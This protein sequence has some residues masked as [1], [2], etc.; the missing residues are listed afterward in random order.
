MDRGETRRRDVILG[1]NQLRHRL[2][3]ELFVFFGMTEG[4][5][6]IDQK[7]FS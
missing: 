1:L 4:V 2:M 5:D 7:H 6:G 3:L